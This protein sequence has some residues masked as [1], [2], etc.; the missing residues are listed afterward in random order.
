MNTTQLNILKW[1]ARMI[2]LILFIFG[3]LFYFGY[4]NPLP[5]VDPDYTW[6]ENTWLTLVPFIFIW[7]LVW[8]RYEKIWGY[9]IIGPIVIG[10]LLWILADAN[11]SINFLVL[12]IPGI[13]FLLY[14][15]NKKL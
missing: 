11:F 14:W 9:L 15:Y 6:I 13:L 12:L 10:F 5:F 7:L 1:S 2:S 8:W 4:W 3:V